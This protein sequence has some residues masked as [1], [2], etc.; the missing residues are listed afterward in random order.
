MVTP[1]Q[2]SPC[3]IRR[4]S[5]RHTSARSIPGREQPPACCGS[6]ARL[7]ACSP[8][9]RHFYPASVLGRLTTPPRSVGGLRVYLV[10]AADRTYTLAPGSPGRPVCVP[11]IGR[12]WRLPERKEGGEPATLVSLDICTT[13]EGLEAYQYGGGSGAV[14]HPQYTT[15]SPPRQGVTLS[16]LV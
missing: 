6:K 7:T 3:L 15:I 11:T 5:P 13:P 9:H 8:P 16:R 10:A 1:C 2:G 14:C 12:L 4:V